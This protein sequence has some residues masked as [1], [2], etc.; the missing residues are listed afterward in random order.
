MSGDS[1]L[2][3]SSSSAVKLASELGVTEK[4]SMLILVC[5]S[6]S[7]CLVDAIFLTLQP[8]TIFAS[9]SSFSRS[10]TGVF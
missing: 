5:V 4:V 3:S 1:E 8:D 7:V 9:L 6:D 2:S 10:L